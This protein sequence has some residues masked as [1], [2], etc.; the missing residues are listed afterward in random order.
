MPRQ[1]NALVLLNRNR[2]SFAELMRAAELEPA[3]QLKRLTRPKWWELRRSYEEPCQLINCTDNHKKPTPSQTVCLT[4][5]V[6]S[7]LPGLVS[8]IA[9]RWILGLTLWGISLLSF[10]VFVLLVANE[11]WDAHAEELNE[12]RRKF[13]EQPTFALTN[14]LMRE[15]KVLETRFLGPSSPI[16]EAR[17]RLDERLRRAEILTEKFHERA[18]KRTGALQ[19]TLYRSKDRARRL[20]TRIQESRDQ[21][22]ARIQQVERLFSDWNKRIKAMQDPMEDLLLIR[23][24]EREEAET[25]QEIIEA[26]DLIEH[27]VDELRTNIDLMKDVIELRLPEATKHLLATPE[28][29]DLEQ[30][31]RV[32]DQVVSVAFNSLPT[33]AP[34]DL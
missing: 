30:E 24:L 25:E 29:E 26:E 1:K 19:E 22:E 8:F 6:L 27:M 3:R 18:K 33:P 32:F 2:T 14:S 4:A 21:L 9:S 5:C 16:H 17:T 23:Q 11:L 7:F 31:L 20:E 28:S 15:L 13:E 10:Q 34:E 12:E